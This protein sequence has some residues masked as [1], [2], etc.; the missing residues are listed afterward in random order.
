MGCG[1][2]GD[3]LCRTCLVTAGE[4]PFS[5]CGG[6]RSLT[7][8]NKT[9]K[10]C[11]GWLNI[12]AVFV[13]TRYE[14]LYEQLVHEL[15]FEKKRDAIKPI[16]TIMATAIPSINEKVI[17]CPIPTASSR[18]RQRGFDHAEFIAK[19]FMKLLP[20]ETPWNTWKLDSLLARKTNIRQVGSSRSRRIEQM[21]KEFYIKTGVEVKGKTILL[22]DDVMTTGA[23]LS[24]AA[25]TLKEAGAK[26]IYAL[27]FAQK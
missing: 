8:D 5:R 26:R 13:S 23:S 20:K 7:Q 17:V 12:Y 27:V 10:S 22:L 14:G 11:K 3:I 2:E 1:S 18:V 24:A 21:K 9:C 16:S 4:P 25:R 19:S 6:C 15:K